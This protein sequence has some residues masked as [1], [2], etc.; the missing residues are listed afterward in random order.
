MSPETGESKENGNEDL[1]GAET[2]SE[3][4]DDDLFQAAYENVVYR[5]ST[6]DGKDGSLFDFEPSPNEDYLQQRSQVILEYARFIDQLATVWK[7]LAVIWTTSVANQE[8]DALDT[9]I[10][11]SID[12]LL[13]SN[14]NRL[15]RTASS[16]EELSRSIQS[17][18]ISRMGT[19]PESMTEYN[20]LR[21]MKDSL[22]EQ[23]VTARVSVIES[24]HY[25]AA[26][27]GQDVDEDEENALALRLLRACMMGDQQAAKQLWLQV[28]E[29]WKTQP[30]LYVPLNRGGDPTQIVQ[31]RSRHQLIQSFMIWL[32][33]SGL[34]TETYRLLE[35][36]REM[37]SNSVGYGAI[38]EFD[39]M[40]EIACRSLVA[41]LVDSFDE[42][43][44]DQLAS[45]LVD[46]VE[47]MTEPLLRLWLEH[48]RTLRLSVLEPASNEETWEEIVEFIRE[49]GRELFTQRFLN[50]G[51]IHGIL[52][53]GVENWLE[54][55]ATYGDEEELGSLIEAVE[56]PDARKQ[57]AP[58][59]TM[60]LETIAE[61]YSEYR[62]YNSITTQSD[63][64]DLLFTLLD[65]LRLRVSYDRVSW[66]LTPVIIAH[67]V[68]AERH[69]DVASQM[70]REGLEKRIASE[71]KRHMQKLTKLQKKYAMAL[72][73]VSKRINEKFM[74]P[75]AIDYLCSLIEPATTDPNE[76][77]RKEKFELIRKEA[78]RFLTM[79]SGAGHDVP[80]WLVAMVD[81]I[82]ALHTERRIS[83]LEIMHDRMKPTVTLNS[84]EVWGPN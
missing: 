28:R 21:M 78:D 42:R 5:D 37:E 32:A 23:V 67:K 77:K 27:T 25:L 14:L 13:E 36:I 70:W 79:P 1:I 38:T 69:C 68:L 26:A 33:R 61:N 8:P 40:F 47:A 12:E 59:L 30:I 56:D 66:N 82:R 39:D 60:V 50:W 11:D 53:Q 10:S 2:D 51:N 72:P 18:R 4:D 48:S 43:D 57:I 22:L 19:D 20:R 34:L 6:D 58:K 52:H 63:Q 9:E 65:F 81:T 62:D 84:E 16:L 41:V 46:Q 7:M 71:A 24:V 35:L 44:A 73:S 3:E 64:G 83:L 29:H 80:G 49:Y 75:L 54:Q 17:Y 76:E 55:L 31:T 74:R 15:K 45:E